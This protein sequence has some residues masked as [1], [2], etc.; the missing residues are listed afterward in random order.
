MRDMLC[1]EETSGV[2]GHFNEKGRIDIYN[3]LRI[4]IKR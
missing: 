4:K 2:L 3:V 1:N